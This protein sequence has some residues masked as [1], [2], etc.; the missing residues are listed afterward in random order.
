MTISL[1]ALQ[2][3]LPNF[4]REILEDWLLVYANSEGWPPKVGIDG[5]PSGRWRYL[6]K[7]R[8]LPYWQSLKWERVERHVSPQALHPAT[9]DVVVQ[10]IQAAVLGKAGL[11][12]SSIPDL[13]PRF[14][15]IVDYLSVHGVLPRPPALLVEDGKLT[16]LDG[17]HRMSAYLYCLGYS[18][19]G[20]PKGLQVE[21]KQVQTYWVAEG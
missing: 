1:D 8:P 10:M 13:V 17:N 11:Y 4:P 14:N 20:I 21:T 3:D 18:K 5:V 9:Q 12:S 2:A 6:L 19:L 16:C 15:R 7:L